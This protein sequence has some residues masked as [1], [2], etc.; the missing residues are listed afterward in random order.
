ML[1]LAIAIAYKRKDEQYTSKPYLDTFAEIPT[2]IPWFWTEEQ[3]AFL[4]GS[5][6]LQAIRDTKAAVYDTYES[7]L[8]RLPQ[9]VHV[10]SPDEF[11]CCWAH[12]MS[13]GFSVDLNDHKVLALV[14]LLDML[15]HN[16]QARTEWQFDVALQV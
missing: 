3:L 1:L 5:P 9:L 2:D 8:Q 12:V 4:E 11:V 15:H 6:A 13:R 10:A 7:L 14:P 16:I